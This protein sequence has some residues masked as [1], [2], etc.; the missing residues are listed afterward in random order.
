MQMRCLYSTEIKEQEYWKENGGKFMELKSMATS[1]IGSIEVI[2]P[3]NL[4][5]LP[6]M[7][8]NVVPL[9]IKYKILIDNIPIID[10]IYLLKTISFLVY[11]IVI[12]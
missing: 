1:I 10:N 2:I 7:I 9:S 3:G 12:A 8:N 11:G 5:K 4:D 6:S